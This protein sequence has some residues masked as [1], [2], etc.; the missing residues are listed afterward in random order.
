MTRQEGE[1]E[2]AEADDLFMKLRSFVVSSSS[3]PRVATVSLLM[4]VADIY[5]TQADP[6]SSYKLLFEI[7]RRFLDGHDANKQK[8]KEGNDVLQ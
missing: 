1:A 7:L 4:L 2:L 8:K 6:D 3:G 5:H